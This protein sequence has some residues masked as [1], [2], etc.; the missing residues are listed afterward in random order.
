MILCFQLCGNS[1]G[2]AL[3]CFS[4]TMPPCTKQGPYRNGLSRSERKSPDNSLKHLWDELEWR[5]RARPN[6]PI[7]VL[8]LTNALVAEREASPCSN[9][10]TSSGKPSQKSGGCYSRGP[11]PYY[12][13]WV[14]N[15]MFDEQVFTYFCSCC[16]ITTKWL[17]LFWKRF[18]VIMSI[19]D[20]T[21]ITTSLLQR[22]TF[23]CIWD[24]FQQDFILFLS[25]YCQQYWWHYYQH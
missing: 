24:T 21:T 8:D 19:R 14:W 1:L 18:W 20:L 16:V 10:P 4:M 12:C 6:R 3:S 5:L 22:H 25:N 2:K 13:L 15:E 17:C 11:T 7:S 23:F 9:V